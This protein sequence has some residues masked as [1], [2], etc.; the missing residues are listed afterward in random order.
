MGVWLNSLVSVFIV[1]SISLIGIVTL[2]ISQNS[3]S[4]ILLWL[5]SFSAGA[6]F[7]G[8]FIHIIPEVVEEYGF[9]AKVSVFLLMG[10]LMFFVL[11]KFVHW[12]HCHVPT[13]KSHPHP[14]AVMN[15]VGDSFHNLIDGMVIGGAYLASFH[16]G[17]TTTVAVLLHEIPQEIGD[18]GV[19]L[20][21]GMSKF[22][23]LLS[24]FLIA[25][26]S[27]LGVIIS[28]TLGS[29]IESY[30]M[31]LL[32]LTAGGFIYIAGSDLIPELKKECGASKSLIQL[33]WLV[34]GVAV[35]LLLTLLENGH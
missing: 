5:V 4:K 10:I 29:R 16:L 9:T 23:A 26:T 24:N 13:S 25:L 6:L 20:H 15:L 12:R 31:F 18:F 14:L 17:L 30:N 21:A 34:L 28:L 3:L 7:G 27:V 32:P 33:V 35:M 1:S 22:K 19:L 11:E 8:T 2:L